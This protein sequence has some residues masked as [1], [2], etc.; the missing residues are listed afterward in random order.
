MHECEIQFGNHRRTFLTSRAR[1]IFIDT[2]RTKHTGLPRHTRTRKSDLITYRKAVRSG[3]RIYRNAIN[4]PQRAE[5]AQQKSPTA[6]SRA[7]GA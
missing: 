7:F 2:T 5:T 3:P 6:N 4:A 1:I